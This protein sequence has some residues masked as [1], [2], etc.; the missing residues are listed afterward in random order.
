MRNRLPQ[1][2]LQAR[3]RPS[4]PMDVCMPRRWD[5]LT[6]SGWQK[7]LVTLRRRRMRQAQSLRHRNTSAESCCCS[8]SLSML[9]GVPATRT[10]ATQ[11]PDLIRPV[12]SKRQ[13]TTDNGTSAAPLSTPWTVTHAIYQFS[14]F[15]CDICKCFTGRDMNPGQPGRTSPGFTYEED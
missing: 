8:P 7:S 12:L 11:R 15:G 2:I 3:A 5:T 6:T 4:D 1:R 10:V 9:F 13:A 14:V